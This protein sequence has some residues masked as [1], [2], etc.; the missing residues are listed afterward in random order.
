MRVLPSDMNEFWAFEIDLQY[1]GGAILDVETRVAVQDLD[2]P[3]GD[4]PDVDSA[5][6]HDAKPDLLEGFEQFGKGKQ[7]EENVEKIDQTNEGTIFFNV[8]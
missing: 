6:S 5:A 2:F 7:S 3:E 8:L 4:E 1:S